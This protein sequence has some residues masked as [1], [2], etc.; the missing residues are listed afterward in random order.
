L[1][2]A[3]FCAVAADRGAQRAEVRW[4]CHPTT[5]RASA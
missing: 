4:S 1:A 5:V 3:V 2:D